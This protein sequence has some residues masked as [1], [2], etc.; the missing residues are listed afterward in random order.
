MGMAVS[1][2]DLAG[3]ARDQATAVD[4][5]TVKTSWLLV[6]ARVSVAPLTSWLA[7]GLSERAT[8]MQRSAIW[9]KGAVAELQ[10]NPQPIQ[11]DPQDALRTELDRLEAMLANLA[12]EATNAAEQLTKAD[13]RSR[14]AV[15]DALR[16]VAQASQALKSEARDFASAIRAH[17][18]NVCAI[19]AARAGSA[20]AASTPAE[21]DAQLV[22]LLA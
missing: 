12:R 17:D 9:F 5:R 15:R 3:M 14:G 19:D 7:N 16:Q 11:I 20:M 10:D 8:R 13:G 2:M 21:L 6:A 1:M 22:R 4:H 18:A